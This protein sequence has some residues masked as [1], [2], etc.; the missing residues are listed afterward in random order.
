[1]IL[2]NISYLV[3]QNF[4]RQILE[5]IDVKISNNEISA[6]GRNLSTRNEEVLDCSDKVVMPGLINAHT[7]VSMTLLRG[8]SDDL[9]LNDWLHDVIFPA[10]EKLG[11]EDAY[12]GAKLGCLEMLKSGTTTFN[13]MYDHM[14]QVAEAVDETGMRAVLSR[15]VLDVDGKGE[16]RVNEAVDFAI[17]YNDHGRITPGFAPHAVYTA[18][19]DVLTNLKEFAEDRDTVYHIHVSETRSEVEDFVKENYATP[20]QH[21][22]NLDLVDDNL[23]AAHCVW[24]MDEEK[25]MMEEKGGT[26]VH[27]PAANLKLGSGIADIPDFL[28][29]GINVALGTD[30]VASNNNLNLFEEAKLAGLLHK[31]DSPTEITAQEILDMMTINGAKALGMEDE[32][33]SVEIGKK[34]DLITINLNSEEM[35]PVHGKEGLISNIIFAFDGKVE[36][37][38]VDGDLV[39]KESKHSSV[40]KKDVLEGVEEKKGKF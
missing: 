2:K 22:D 8:I 34:A 9:E 26:V 10:E 32:I 3:T 38:V 25:D 37:V 13:D 35:Q 24:M 20:L 19:S 1:M 39:V 4:D 30:G 12:V 33:G 36:D 31:R 5:N 6:I 29:R 21:L 27:N 28:D 11:P 40:D 18:S 17:D 23:I 7:H 15:G 16:K 14:D